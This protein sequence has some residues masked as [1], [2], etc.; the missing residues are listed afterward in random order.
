MKRGSR[1]WVI[2]YRTFSDLYNL[3][4]TYSSV[5]IC[6]TNG[7]TRAEIVVDDAARATI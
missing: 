4:C 3:S 2:L 5:N 7:T 1:P 6:N